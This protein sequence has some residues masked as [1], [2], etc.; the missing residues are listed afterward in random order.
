[1]LGVTV[2]DVALGLWRGGGRV[3]RCL[4]TVER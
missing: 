1:V 2:A 3:S 4:R